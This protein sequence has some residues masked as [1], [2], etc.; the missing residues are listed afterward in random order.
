MMGT[1]Y[2][3]NLKKQK[4]PNTNAIFIKGGPNK[5]MIAMSISNGTIYHCNLFRLGLDMIAIS[6]FVLESRDYD[7]WTNLVKTNFRSLQ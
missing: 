7:F 4:G 5:F 1:K 2:D 3:C 6:K